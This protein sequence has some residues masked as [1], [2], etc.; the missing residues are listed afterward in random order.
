MHNSS[1]DGITFFGKIISANFHVQRVSGKIEM[2]C[3][4][5]GCLAWGIWEKNPDKF[6]TS[7]LRSPDR[8]R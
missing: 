8:H 6:H 1:Q 7:S 3:V 5:F 4:F 2:V